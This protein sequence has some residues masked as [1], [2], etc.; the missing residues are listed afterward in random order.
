[1]NLKYVL[2]FFGV[3]VVI[4]RLMGVGFLWSFSLIIGACGIFFYVRHKFKPPSSDALLVASI[5]SLSKSPASTQQK[6]LSQVASL[7]HNRASRNRLRNLDVTSSLLK[8]LSS[9]PT[10]SSIAVPLLEALI[11]LCAEKDIRHKIAEKNLQDFLFYA[12][13]DN[14]LAVKLRE[15]G[16]RALV[17]LTL[18]EKGENKFREEGGIPQIL[19]VLKREKCEPDLLLQCLRLLINLAFNAQNRDVI[20][21]DGEVLG[22]LA[23]M[24]EEYIVYKNQ[25]KKNDQKKEEEEEEEEDDEEEE[26]GEEGEGEEGESDSDDS[27]DEE[28]EDLEDGMKK[29][30]AMRVVRL[31][32]V[33]AQT[34]QKNVYSK[35]AT[36]QVGEALAKMLVFEESDHE[37][38]KYVVSTVAT[39]LKK[40]NESK[41]TDGE[42]FE[43]CKGFAA[44]VTEN[45][46]AF[47][48]VEEMTK[49]K[50][51]RVAA[52]AQNVV[53]SL[54]DFAVN[55]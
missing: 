23:M 43:L 8:F 48:I 22:K 6:V 47:K 4:L 9:H 15:Q 28:D 13:E 49:D 11:D 30:I 40:G 18:D 37:F 5:N 3:V 29:N 24:L 52:M 12:S 42:I 34:S 19:K 1:M 2:I 20:T 35:V 45:K 17:N 46:S 7:A 54:A 32:G 31:M 26:E 36:P 41:T 33:I 38:S 55:S 10:D 14:A 51:P 50:E 53:D 44:K 16:I 27:S 21:S 25:K 39:I